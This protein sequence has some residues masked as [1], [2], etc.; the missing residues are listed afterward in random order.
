MSVGKNEVNHGLNTFTVK[1]YT[2]FLKDCFALY[3]PNNQIGVGMLLQLNKDHIIV[4]GSLRLI[5][6][7]LYQS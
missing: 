5:L 7:D 3:V 2:H 1:S 6:Y 4:I